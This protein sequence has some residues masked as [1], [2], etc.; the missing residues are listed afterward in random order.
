[1]WEEFR[2][3]ATWREKNRPPLSNVNVI[4]D[5]TWGGSRSVVHTGASQMPRKHEKTCYMVVIAFEIIDG[6]YRFVKKSLRVIRSKHKH[7]KIF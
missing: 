5:L 7:S 6:K 4:A 2:K 1:M 3:F